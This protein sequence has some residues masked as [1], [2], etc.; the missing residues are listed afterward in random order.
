MP[1]LGIGPAKR[2]MGYAHWHL[3]SLLLTW[4][5]SDPAK[6]YYPLVS[7]RCV[8]FSFDCISRLLTKLL[9]GE[10]VDLLCRRIGGTII[11]DPLQ[12]DEENPFHATPLGLRPVHLARPA[13]CFETV[14]SCYLNR[15]VIGTR[16]RDI[17]GCSAM[18][19]YRLHSSRVRQSACWQSSRTSQT[20]ISVLGALGVTACF[21]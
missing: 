15:A 7:Y 6:R 4:D 19:K 21:V 9:R 1:S 5:A 8:Y 20:K 10:A 11:D 18:I 12:R 3:V 13:P 17:A 16:H 2:F 14:Q